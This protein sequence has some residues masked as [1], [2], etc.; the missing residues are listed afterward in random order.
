MIHKHTSSGG[1]FGGGDF[2]LPELAWPGPPVRC[3]G[4]RLCHVCERFRDIIRLRV[5]AVMFR[6]FSLKITTENSAC[7]WEACKHILPHA[8]EVRLDTKKYERHPK[9]IARLFD[10]FVR[11]LGEK[12]DRLDLIG[13]T[14]TDRLY[15][16]LKPVLKRLKVFKWN[17]FEDFSS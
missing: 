4:E 17:D 13:V 14:M 15:E 6:K 7:I 9:V 12:V 8:T 5:F 16:Q 3:S 2:L 11:N 1:L 10:T